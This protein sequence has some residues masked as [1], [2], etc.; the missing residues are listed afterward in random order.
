MT[1]R[2]RYEFDR[3]VILTSILIIIAAI[4]SLLPKKSTYSSYNDI[5]KGPLEYGVAPRSI[6]SQ[7]NT[8][9]AFQSHSYF[10]ELYAEP[11]IF[12][13]AHVHEADNRFNINIFLDGTRV[14]F[15]VN[16]TSVGEEDRYVFLPREVGKIEVEIQNQNPYILE[17]EI[18]IYTQRG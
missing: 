18:C 1:L 7:N 13:T 10:F 17:Y 8:L 15:R 14:W 9:L 5:Y 4:Y 12:I 2:T 3:I 11:I 6:I 16:I